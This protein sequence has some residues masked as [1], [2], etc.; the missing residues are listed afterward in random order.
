MLYDIVTSDFL[1]HLLPAHYCA[2]LCKIART[3]LF[4]MDI[5]R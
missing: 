5:Y 4:A 2:R 1:E 3:A